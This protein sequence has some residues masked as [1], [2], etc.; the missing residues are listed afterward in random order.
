MIP[1][2][3]ESTIWKNLYRARDAAEFSDFPRQ[4]LGCV[5][6]QGNKV[7]AIGYNTT[8]TNPMQKMFNRYRHFDFETLND[9]TIHA[10]MHLLLKTRYWDVDWSRTTLY[11]YREFK[12]N[13][14]PAL[15]KPC[16]ACQA[17]LWGRGI[18]EIYYTNHLNKKG[19]S[20]L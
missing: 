1:I 7:L 20:K 3:S 16:P 6:M 17:A 9:G 2:P 14:K 13:H 5:L 8:K 10:E 12:R 19:W 4:K 18:T 15:A 11:I